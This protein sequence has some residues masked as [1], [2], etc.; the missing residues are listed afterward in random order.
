MPEIVSCPDCDRKLRVPD[1]LLGKKVKCPGCNVMFTAL[2]AGGGAVVTRNDYEQVRVR[3]RVEEPAAPP[4]ARRRRE[5]DYDDYDDRPRRRRRDDDYEDEYQD[6]YQDSPR[7]QRAGWRMMCTGLNLYSIGIWVGVAGV[8]IMALG[9][10]MAWLLAEHG[11]DVVAKIVLVLLWFA[12]L[13]DLILRCAG[14]GLCMAVPA[15]P[16]TGRKPLAITAFSLYA[17]HALLLVIA[18]IMMMLEVGFGNP[19]SLFNTARG[20]GILSILAGIVATAALIV[21]LLA[22]RSAAIGVRARRLGGTFM[23]LLITFCVFF[24][25]C[26]LVLVIMEAVG[27]NITTRSGAKAYLVISIILLV[28]GLACYIGIE[29]WYAFTLQSLRATAEAHRHEL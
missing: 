16:G 8:S 23:A 25:T 28:L 2:V 7:R 27:N 22:N 29:I 5:D 24:V 6:D 9:F 14:A 3:R 4:P 18:F 1:H 26:I 13:V 10:L 12:G 15:K 21:F 19:L 17:L 20:V 11:G